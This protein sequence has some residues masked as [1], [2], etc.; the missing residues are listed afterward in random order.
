MKAAPYLRVRRQVGNGRFLRRAN[1][2]NSSSSNKEHVIH[3]NQP[4]SPGL[5]FSP[6]LMLLRPHPLCLLETLSTFPGAPGEKRGADGAALHEGFLGRMNRVLLG[7]EGRR[8]GREGGRDLGIG[9]CL[10][11]CGFMTL[12]NTPLPLRT[13][14]RGKGGLY[15]KKRGLGLVSEPLQRASCTPLSSVLSSGHP[16]VP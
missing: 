1:S 4:N 14:S 15:R 8:D 2:S 7:T 6:S 11:V 12:A 10:Q 13:E 16:P 5:V 9:D 3:S